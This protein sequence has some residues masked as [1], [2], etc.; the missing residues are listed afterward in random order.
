MHTR[1]GS[2]LAA[3]FLTVV[4]APARSQ[5]PTDSATV[6]GRVAR[7]LQPM[8]EAG[9][10]SGVVL[11]ARGDTVLYQGAFGWAD[12]PGGRP[13]TVN[14]PSAVASISKPLTGIIVAGLVAQ[15]RLSLDDRL[16]RC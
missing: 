16:N 10:L 5:V 8:A 12:R 14:T 13:M 1:L 2:L 4:A 7:Y 11:L 15:G 6:A 9:A 3:T